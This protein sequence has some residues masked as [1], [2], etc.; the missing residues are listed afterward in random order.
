M[1]MQ[2][3]KSAKK[4]LVTVSF[5]IASQQTCLFFFCVMFNITNAPE[6]GEQ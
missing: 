6:N 5:P 3:C 1:S 2:I 4:K